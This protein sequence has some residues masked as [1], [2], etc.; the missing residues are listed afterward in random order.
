MKSRLVFDHIPK[1]AG[2]SISSAL[3]RMFGQSPGLPE[4]F[5]SHLHVISAA[6][7]RR[8]LGGHLWFTPHEPL[9]PGWYYCTLLRDPIDRFLSQYWFYRS[10]G[11]KWA[12]QS[13]GLPHED[14]QVQAAADLD[15][16]QFLASSDS[17]IRLA[18]QNVQAVHFARRLTSAPNVL[19]PD[20]LFKAA[21]ASLEEYDLVGTFD[22]L[23]GFLDAISQDIG[24]A[25]VELPRL[26][27]TENRRQ[28]RETPEHLIAVMREAN[29]VDL[30]LYE[31]AR[32]R[33]AARP[34]PTAGS[35]AP[36][37]AASA[38]SEASRFEFGNREALIRTVECRGVQ[39]GSREIKSGE[40]LAIAVEFEARRALEDMTIGIAVRDKQ[41]NL[42][43]GTNTRL[44]GMAVPVP[45][46]GVFRG[47]FR[48]EARLGPG[49]YG[50]T[51]AL[52]RGVSHDEGCYH[53]LDRASNFEVV[54]YMDAA[55][56]GLTDLEMRI[57]PSSLESFGSTRA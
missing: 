5:N 56:D 31:W 46:A 26:N 27:V 6:G 24:L 36:A 33:F 16:E 4:Y 1:T 17:R 7:T 37:E 10:Q 55:F 48:L 41:G 32:E 49:E 9:A 2:T 28:E 21:V 25:R 29:G 42:V 50:V 22:D 15:L 39:S 12:A 30:K 11:Q 18:F 23:Q 20:S 45:H 51:I 40:N 3:E 43:Y 35:A 34:R 13:G 47:E 52:H 38:T 8:V 53:W 44:M 19:S 57:L 14:P 54:G